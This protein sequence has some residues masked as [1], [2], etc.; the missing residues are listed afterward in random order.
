M[1]WGEVTLAPEGP[2]DRVHAGPPRRVVGDVPLVVEAAP[3]LA[4]ASAGPSAL[5]TV[6]VHAG[7]LVPYQPQS[8]ARQPSH[9]AWRHV[10]HGLNVDAGLAMRPCQAVFVKHVVV[11]ISHRFVNMRSAHVHIQPLICLY[12]LY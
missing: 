1:G 11:A 12:G 7:V 5:D 8:V 9:L 4:D 6:S 10:A 3:R 2:S